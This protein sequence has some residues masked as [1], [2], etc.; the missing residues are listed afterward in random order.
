MALHGLTSP[1]AKGYVR[2]DHVDV[3]VRNEGRIIEPTG[4]DNLRENRGGTL[5]CTAARSACGAGD[6]RTGDRARAILQAN[7]V[8]D[9]RAGRRNRRRAAVER[10][11]S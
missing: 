6:S 3:W 2:Q 5:D 8:L 7:N 11:Q 9:Q 10:M 1:L 4:F